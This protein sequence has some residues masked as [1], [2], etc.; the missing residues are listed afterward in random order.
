MITVGPMTAA[1]RRSGHV[2]GRDT[3][4]A[5]PKVRWA[6]AYAPQ[7]PAQAP[8][9]GARNSMGNV[10]PAATRPTSTVISTISIPRRR[11]AS[12]CWR[13]SAWVTTITVKKASKISDT[14][15]IS[16]ATWA[17]GEDP[18]ATN[19]NWI[20]PQATTVNASLSPTT[21]PRISSR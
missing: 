7:A 9:T 11:N 1:S 17:V 18:I 8:T 16:A 15:A 21:V 10:A 5:S 3:R 19:T 12:R 4:G 2:C 13:I 6:T 20:N 14:E